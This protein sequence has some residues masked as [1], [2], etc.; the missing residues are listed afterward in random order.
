MELTRV[1]LPGMLERG[2]GHVVNI[3][4]LAGKIAV[5]VPRLLLR[6]PST[7][8]VGF[9]HSLRAELGPEPVGF[10]A[11]CPG[12]ISRVGHVRAARAPG[13]RPAARDLGKLPP[14]AVGEAVV[15]GIR[16]N[17]AQS[18]VVNER[19][20]GGRAR[21]HAARAEGLSRA[22]CAASA[23]RSSRER[24]AEATASR[25]TSRSPPSCTREPAT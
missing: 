9:T 20:Q 15:K 19:H 22:C 5:A 25:S 24:F 21:A 3:A 13:S 7:A 6:P 4:S 8:V 18:M 16:E 23:P 1:V 12:F 10:T 14:E 11:I 2:R 17:R